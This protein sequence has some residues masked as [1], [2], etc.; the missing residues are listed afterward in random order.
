MQ[1]LMIH[2][3]TSKVCQRVIFFFLS[4]VVSLQTCSVNKQQERWTNS[5][6]LPGVNWKSEAAEN[7]EQEFSFNHSG[8]NAES[9]PLKL[10]N[11]VLLMFQTQIAK[12]FLK[13]F[14]L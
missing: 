7:K 9:L 3:N 4:L 1:S 2:F 6:Q 11:V 13:V 8:C 14:Y 10:T 12:H 5:R